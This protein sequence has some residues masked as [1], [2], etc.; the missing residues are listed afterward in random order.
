MDNVNCEELDEALL[1]ALFRQKAVIVAWAN[2][3]GDSKLDEWTKNWWAGM[4]QGT[5]LPEFFRTNAEALSQ[6]LDIPDLFEL[7][8]AAVI[9]DLAASEF[10]SGEFSKSLKL[11]FEV[12]DALGQRRGRKS[13]KIRALKKKTSLIHKETYAIKQAVL[14]HYIRNNLDA[15]SNEAAAKIIGKANLVRISHR[16][17]VGYIAEHKKLLGICRESEWGKAIAELQAQAMQK[18]K[19]QTDLKPNQIA[20]AESIIERIKEH[21][22]SRIFSVVSLDSSR[23]QSVVLSLERQALEG[24]LKT[25]IHSQAIEAIQSYRDRTSA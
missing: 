11:T 7:M 23:A 9:F 13:Q 6:R 4:Q 12:E 2:E 14:E 20:E 18:L 5:S 10:M 8:G 16:A 24:L 21:E 1:A 15:H 17:L 22:M 3:F 25:P 19:T